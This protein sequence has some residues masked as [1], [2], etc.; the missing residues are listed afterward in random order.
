MFIPTHP[1]FTKVQTVE[2]Y[3][4]YSYEVEEGIKYTYWFGEE[5]YMYISSINT[6]KEAVE[7]INKE[8]SS[9]VVVFIMRFLSSKLNAL[10]D[11]SYVDCIYDDLLK[12]EK[13]ALSIRFFSTE[14]WV[15]AKMEVFTL[16][17][18]LIYPSMDEVVQLFSAADIPT[19]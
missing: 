8:I 4:I 13:Y 11:F 7:S 18:K 12:N 19:K 3:I 10:Q 2:D 5:E 9:S 14:D 17:H 15:E 6:L 1:M 16:D